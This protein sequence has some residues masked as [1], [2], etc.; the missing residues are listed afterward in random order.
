MTIHAQVQYT[1]TANLHVTV[2]WTLTTEVVRLDVCSVG[3]WLLDFCLE[4]FPF[5]A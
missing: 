3:K 5:W 1:D 2:G 4:I